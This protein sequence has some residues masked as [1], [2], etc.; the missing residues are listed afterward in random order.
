MRLTTTII[1]VTTFV[2]SRKLIAKRMKRVKVKEK[3]NR[4]GGKRNDKP[5]VKREREKNGKRIERELG[6]KRLAEN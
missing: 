4:N 3:E 6:N 1:V 5:N 2:P